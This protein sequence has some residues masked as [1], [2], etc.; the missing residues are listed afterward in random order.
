MVRTVRPKFAVLNLGCKVNR[1]ESDG[2]LAQLEGR[3]FELSSASHADVVVVNTCTVTGEAE[4]KTR[5][6]VRRALRANED[7]TVVVTGC[8]AVIDPGEFQEMSPRVIVQPD[9]TKVV[10]AAL[11][12]VAPDERTVEG[13]LQ[14][15]GFRTPEDGAFDAVGN[16][17]VPVLRMGDSFP[18]RVGIK[19]Q[20]GC[21][22]ACSYC[23]VHVARGRAWSRPAG[24]V[25]AEAVAYARA[26]VKEIVLT[27]INLGSY[28]EGE[29]RL[30]GL[31][32]KLLFATADDGVRFRVSSIEPRDVDEELIAVLAEADGRVCR[33][34]HLPLQAGS[35]KVLR[36][37]RRPYDAAFFGS[38]V[39]RLYRQVPSLS[40]S[41][42]I[43]AGFPGESDREFEE[44]LALARQCRFSKIHAFPYSR[45]E[46][47][48]AAARTDQV[49][50]GVKAA[51]TAQLLALSEGLRS[52]D[53]VR[54]AGTTELVLVEADGRGMTESYHEVALPEGLVPGALIPLELSGEMRRLS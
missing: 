5:K 33:H 34:L 11:D 49:P 36:E 30:A 22:N 53:F 28:R 45:R 38:L 12:A 47:T 20:D 14:G 9:K 52:T 4:K 19:V 21:N 16:A 37:M 25:L 7:A 23:I 15:V 40:L 24:Q 39:D 29:L 43:I 50:D 3:G 1:V 27:G 51:R 8:A 32:R 31:L 17:F 26:G 48:P 54:R 18:T 13:A 41:T 2:F 10:D 46:S 42:D 44:T 6:A 35:S